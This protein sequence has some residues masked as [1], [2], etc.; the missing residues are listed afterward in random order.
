MAIGFICACC[1]TKGERPDDAAVELD[2]ALMCMACEEDPVAQPPDMSVHTIPADT[3]V[4][5]LEAA[6][7]F[8]GLTPTERAYAYALGKAD[9]EGA[10]ICLL[11]CSAEST[12]IF[13]LLQLVF[14]A[15]PVADLLAA[16]AAKGLSDDEVAQAMIYVAAVYGNL[17]NYKSFGDTKFVPALTAAQFKLLLTAGKAPAATVDELWAECCERMYSLPPR[18]RQMGLGKAQ[19]VSTYFSANCDEADA[20]L[21]AKFLESLALSPYNT[22]LFK[23]DADGSYTV[24]LASAKTAPSS[25]DPVGALCKEHAFEHG[26][27]THAFHVVRG[28]HAPLMGRVCAALRE[29]IPHAANDE[30]RKMLARMVSSFDTGSVADHVE[31]SKHWIKDTGPA[32]ESYI[33]FIESYRDPSGM[34]GEWEGFV[35]CVNRE[36]SKKFGA[37]VDGAEELL[38]LFPWPRWQEK[39]TFF[40]PDFTSLEVLAFGSSGV[41]AGIN[42]PNYDDVRQNEGFKNVSL[43]NVLAASYGAGAKP[44]TFVADEDQALFKALKGESFEVQVGV[45]ELLGHGSG[46]LFHRGTPDAERL[47]ADKVAHPL[48]GEPVSGPFYAPGATW[49]STFGKLA[50][51]YEE[52]R[53]ECAGIY[54]C[55]EP[56]VLSVF[57]H[58]GESGAGAPGS[59]HDVAYINWLLMARAGLAGLEFYTPET[60]SW[61]QAHMQARYVILRVLLEAGD[62]LVSL[63]SGVAD[64]DG[65]PDVTVRVARDKVVTVGRKAIGSFLLQLQ[66][67]KSLGDVE[68]GKAMFSRYAE[69]PAEMAALREVVMARKEPRKLLVQPHMHADGAGG[70]ALRQFDE[71]THGMVE[72]FVAR[73]PAEDPELLALYEREKAQVTD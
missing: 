10:K 60:K 23:S 19:G 34:R 6:A 8:E 64:D 59:V 2:A 66:T 39:D 70:V 31:A 51:A 68:V 48:H 5:R 54:L 57:G 16:A 41:P 46:K 73:Y 21:A 44:V 42:I 26:G 18:Q 37:L 65:K 14:S 11:Q 29:A 35:S 25:D 62:G 71:S 50:S 28:D 24:R 30:Q 69:V 63:E 12:P 9:W 33:G 15:Q 58:D 3:G 32:V 61:R 72:S 49:D 1:G 55:L 17:G 45:H 47:L 52:C 43:G 56:R 53:A 40:R 4:V 36:T 38:A 20:A 67:H 7:A 27:A 22:R 13:S